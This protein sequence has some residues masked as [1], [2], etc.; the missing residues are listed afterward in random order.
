VQLGQ[1]VGRA[2]LAQALG[3]ARAAGHAALHIDADPH[4]EAFYR[5]CGAMRIGATAAPID[6]QPQRVRPQLR[7]STQARGADVAPV[8]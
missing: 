1:G 4:A 7:L 3:H 5:R 2:L 6:G 8:R